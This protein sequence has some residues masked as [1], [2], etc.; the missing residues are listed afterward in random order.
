M[1]LWDIIALPKQ[2]HFAGT[3]L[4]VAQNRASAQ[5]IL[6]QPLLYN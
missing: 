2:R 1:L 6:E 3:K 5:A 4:L